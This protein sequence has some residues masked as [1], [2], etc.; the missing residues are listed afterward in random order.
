MIMT[1]KEATS[2]VSNEIDY[3]RID[4]DRKRGIKFSD[5]GTVLIKY[6]EELSDETYHIPDSVTI[7]GWCAFN[8]CTNLKNVVIPDSVTGIFYGA[9]SRCTS[10]KNVVIPDSVIEI[11]DY[12]FDDTCKVIRK[13]RG[14]LGRLFQ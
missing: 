8:G 6:P 4:A 9:F 1:N 13:K 11:G 12:A 5:D 2:K 3:E 7:I 10:L 14:F